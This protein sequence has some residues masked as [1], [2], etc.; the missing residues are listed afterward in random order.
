MNVTR[1]V[2]DGRWVEG[3]ELREEERVT[4]FAWGVD[5]DG[6]LGRREFYGLRCNRRRS[7]FCKFHIH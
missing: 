5:E 6:G 3:E 7:A 2:D 1:D 4:S